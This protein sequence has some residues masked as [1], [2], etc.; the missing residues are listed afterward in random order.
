MFP[1][2]PKRVKKNAKNERGKPDL[3]AK[4]DRVFALYI[5]LRD[6]M[7][8]GY[9][10]CISCGRIKPFK[11]LDCGHFYGRTNMATRFD[12][13]NC[14]AE[15]H[16]CN[17]MK[18]DHLIYYQENLIR[19]IGVARFSALKWKSCSTKHWQNYELAAMIEKYTKEVKRLSHDKGI[20]VNI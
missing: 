16:Y 14:S 4:L 13:D 7:P 1:F 11:E 10:R 2:Y 9:G 17:R 8:N 6:A 5:R 12:E 20:S 3:V 18:A 15:C 19:K